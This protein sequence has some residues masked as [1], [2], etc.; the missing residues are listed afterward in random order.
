[1]KRIPLFLI[2][3]SIA[4]T[5]HSQI[6]TK[7]DS[8]K[9]AQADIWG[10][11]SDDGDS[12]CA[13]TVSEVD[14]KPHIFMRKI[15][16]NNISLQSTPKQLT[17][18]SDFDSISNL[19]DHKSIILND[20]IFVTFSTVSST[21]LFLFKTDIN[22]N[23]IGTIVTVVTGSPT[24]STNDMILTTDSTY[25]YVLYF[26]PPNQHYVNKYDLNLNF[27]SLDTTNTLIHNNI[28]SCILHN[29]DFYMY[30][31]TWLSVNS[32]LIL[33]KW[34]TNWDPAMGTPQILING[35]SAD[36]NYFSTG[37]AYDNL[38]QR[39]Y[40]GM[41]HILSGQTAGQEHIDLLAFDNSFNLLERQHITSMGFIRPHFVLKENFLYITYD[42]LGG[43]YLLKYAV[44]Q[45][46]GIETE[47]ILS[48]NNIYPNPFSTS[49][50]MHLSEKPD[51]AELNIYNLV[52]EKIKTIKNIS[53]QEIKLFRD[54]LPSGIYF[55]RLS[56]DNETITTDKLVI[57][58]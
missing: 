41:A 23:R 47:N 56:Q 17:F 8:V 7:I 29:N 31:G 57:T 26:F 18:G 35:S 36:G 49:A 55:I 15:N 3:C 24:P 46:A 38:N 52:G 48:S 54:N 10:V 4:F 20:Q 34:T 32:D 1:M 9:L 5:S 33:T 25:I 53:G 44:Q 58:D 14:F 21:D 27:I 50:I 45:V 13:T 51:N 2:V 11:L 12:L 30:T 43:V 28:G 6:L 40:V 16:Y 22:G 37:I 42:T 19:T 39:W